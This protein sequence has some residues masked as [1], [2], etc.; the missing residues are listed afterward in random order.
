MKDLYWI[1]IRESEIKYCK[2]LFQDSITILGNNN[3]SMQQKLKRVIGY[4]NVNNFDLIDDLKL[5]YC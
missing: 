1:G 2:N 4:N 5:I 3:R